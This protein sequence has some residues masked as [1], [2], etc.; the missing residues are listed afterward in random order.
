MRYPALMTDLYEL[1]MLAGYF[2]DGMHE[3]PASF[4]L[5]FRNTPFRGSYAVFAGLGTALDYLKELRFTEE[6][7]AYLQSL[8]LFRPAFLNDL[9]NFRFRCKVTALSEGSV[10]FG[11]EPLLTVEGTLAEAQ[12]V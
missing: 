9:R 8:E 10:V 6:E 4:D 3:K 1:T 2:E 12:L 11:N 7:I 5:F